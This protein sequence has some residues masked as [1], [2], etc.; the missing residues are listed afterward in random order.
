[1]TKAGKTNNQ[2][3][4]RAEFTPSQPKMHRP[5]L[6][7]LVR[8]SGEAESDARAGDPVDADTVIRAVNDQGGLRIE[9]SDALAI[10]K[11]GAPAGFMASLERGE[12]GFVASVNWADCALIHLHVFAYQNLKPILVFS[13]G[14]IGVKLTF[15]PPIARAP[16]D[17]GHSFLPPDS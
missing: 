1:V 2:R 8:V 5:S 17:P 4:W 14:D 3:E 15:A 13:F 11:D 16:V 12:R 7:A 10:G 6:V 9:F